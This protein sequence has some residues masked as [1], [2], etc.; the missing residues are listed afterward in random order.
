MTIFKEDAE[1]LQQLGRLKPE[2]TFGY[3]DFPILFSTRDVAGNLHLAMW[4]EHSPEDAV[5]PYDVFLVVPV[6]DE[7]L[8]RIEAKQLDL[9]EAMTVAGGLL[10]KIPYGQNP[11][12]VA[13]VDRVLDLPRDTLPRAGFFLNG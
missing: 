11:W 6:T 9:F 13:V 12:S 1:I 8:A 5:L 3:Y 2:T 7:T 10:V 4:H